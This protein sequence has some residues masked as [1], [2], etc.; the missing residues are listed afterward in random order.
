MPDRLNTIE[1]REVI[2]PLPEKVVRRDG[3]IAVKMLAPGWAP[4]RCYDRKVLERNMPK[5]FPAGTKIFW[6]HPTL[7]DQA[8]RLAIE[9]GG[10][11]WRK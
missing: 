9:S 5:A 3:M 4:S 11:R 2:T 7:A 6:I 8:V 10:G 1:L